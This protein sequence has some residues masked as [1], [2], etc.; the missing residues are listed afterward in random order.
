MSDGPRC[1][2]VVEFLVLL[3]AWLMWQGHVLAC[4]TTSDGAFG[5]GEEGSPG[6]WAIPADEWHQRYAAARAGGGG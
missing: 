1:P 5:V 4:D 2:T 3:S 6:W